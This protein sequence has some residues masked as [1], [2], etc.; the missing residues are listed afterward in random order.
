MADKTV[1]FLTQ[2]DRDIIQRFLDEK[3]RSAVN[4]TQ[5]GREGANEHEEWLVPE[6]YVARVPSGGIPA[7]VGSG[8]ESVLIGRDGDIPGYAD[9]DI[10]RILQTGSRPKLRKVSFVPKK[11]FNLS[12]DAINSIPWIITLRDKFGSWLAA[13]VGDGIPGT[14]TDADELC[15]HLILDCPADAPGTG[16]TVSDG[17]I[18]VCND[19]EKVP[20]NFFAGLTYDGHPLTVPIVYFASGTSSE[21]GGIEGWHYTGVPTVISS[22][23]QLVAITVCCSFGSFSFQCDVNIDGVLNSFTFAGI[24]RISA[25]PFHYT[26]ATAPF[27]VPSYSG[28]TFPL[29]L[30]FSP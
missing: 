24:T 8:D 5:R 27:Q 23:L 13:G 2:A 26:A 25:V 28:S 22:G 29:L 15:G 14:G 9:C 30:E 11:V 4:T 19:G 3:R 17:V 12:T 1:T 7:L 6:V 10:Y 16:S 18:S 20:F 21:C